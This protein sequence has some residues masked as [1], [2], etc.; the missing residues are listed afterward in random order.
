MGASQF[1]LA[2]RATS[3]YG[4]LSKFTAY[5]DQLVSNFETYLS[6]FQLTAS[7]LLQEL[8]DQLGDRKEQCVEMMSVLMSQHHDALVV[9]F[10]KGNWDRVESV[11][12]AGQ[13][14]SAAVVRVSCI[15]LHSYCRLFLCM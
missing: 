13:A 12:L 7:Q 14:R 10:R 4:A 15:N 8:R 3:A 5:V 6:L 1:D 9:H 2:T 11:K